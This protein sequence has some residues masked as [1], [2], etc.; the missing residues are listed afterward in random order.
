MNV[1]AH[2]C[3]RRHAA[4]VA[5][6][7]VSVRALARARGATQRQSIRTSGSGW[8]P[9]ARRLTCVAGC[10]SSSCSLIADRVTIQLKTSDGSLSTTVRDVCACASHL[11]DP[12]RPCTTRLRAS[13]IRCLARDGDSLHSAYGSDCRSVVCTALGRLD[14]AGLSRRGLR[15]QDAL[16]TAAVL[17][18]VTVRTVSTHNDLARTEGTVTP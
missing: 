16:A 15:I 2:V 7:W 17:S 1:R 6:V 9:L 5:A 14:R 12:L 11:Q 10:F 4:P 3:T 13:G 18:A 8:M